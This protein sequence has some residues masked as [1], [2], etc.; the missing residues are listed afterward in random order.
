MKPNASVFRAS[1]LLV[2]LL[3]LAGCVVMPEGPSQMSLPGTGKSFDQFRA[4]DASCRQYASSTLGGSTPEQAAVDSTGRSAVAG[5]AIGA[6]SGALIGGSGSAAAVG[7]GVGLIGGALVGSSTGYSSSYALQNRYD[8]SYTQCMY[9]KGHKVPVYGNYT[10]SN[11]R[12]R[13]TTYYSPPPPPPP[14]ASTPPPPPPS[15]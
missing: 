3:A 5:T 9:A 12:S 14:S 10:S 2:A 7:A 13:S 4:D 8:A 15:R 11:E 6:A 1:G